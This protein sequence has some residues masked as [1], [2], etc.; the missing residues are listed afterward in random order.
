MKNKGKTLTLKVGVTTA[1]RK[2]GRR[3][4]RKS[5]RVKKKIPIY[6]SKK[7]AKRLKRYMRG[8][9]IFSLLILPLALSG[10]ARAGDY[11]EPEEVVTVSALGFDATENGVRVSMQAVYRGGEQVKASEGESVRYALS[12]LSGSGSGRLELS[13]CALIAIGDGV[14]ERVLSEIFELCEREREISDA[15]LFIAC[16]RAE[17]LLSLEGAAGY[18][19]VSS[20]RSFPGGAGLF[21]KNRFYEIRNKEKEGGE[22]AMALPYFYVSDGGYSIGG[23][24]LYTKRAERVILD[25]REGVL[26]LMIEGIYTS[27]S[28]DY[29]YDGE[30]SSTEIRSSRTEY[31]RGD[32]P[33]VTCRL[34]VGDRLSAA[35]K[36]AVERDLSIGAKEL[37]HMLRERYG[38][39]FGFSQGGEAWEFEFIVEET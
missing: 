19:V 29:S 38:K 5:R 18:D 25:R 17:E 26:Y 30:V 37:Y 12:S 10:C 4:M 28:V 13:H 14:S 8:F 24:K 1:L 32:K 9:G 7:L 20:M 15:V 3:I 23:L 11:T 36:K 35:E 27:G 22:G 16:H 21:S 34:T 2:R 6:M 31:Q 33:L 39:I